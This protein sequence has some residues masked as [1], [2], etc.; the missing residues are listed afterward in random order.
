MTINSDSEALNV[1]AVILAG[2]RG[3]RM[4][5]EDKGLIF[6]QHQPLYIHVM[7]RLISQA[8]T[9]W[10]SA[11]RNLATYQQSGVPVIADTMPN[12]PGPLAGMVTAMKYVETDW[13]LFSPCDT[14]LLP[15]NLL[16]HLW[17][18]KGNALAVWARSEVREHPAM[19]LL[20]RSLADEL[21]FY[22]DRGERRLLAFLRQIGGHSVLFSNAEDAFTNFNHPEDLIKKMEFKA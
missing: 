10:I 13:V 2:G 18:N 11:N 22:L 20:H 17:C 3:S 19:A 4:G 7:Q 8:G 9:V 15:E 5:G 16:I 21:Q 6:W 12:F 1:T 14:P